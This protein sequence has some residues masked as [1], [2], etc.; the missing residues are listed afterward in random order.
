MLRKVLSHP[1]TLG[2]RRFVRAV[3]ATCAVILAVAFVT[4]LTV[5]LGPVLRA[6]AETEGSR[7]MERPMH[8]GRLSVHLWRGRFVVE[9][10]LIEG[11]TPE[12]RPFLIARRIDVS[13]PWN[14]L[15]NRRIVFDT[16]EMTDWRM[17]VELLKDGRHNFPKFTPRTPRGPS[18]WTTTL[19]YVRAHRGEFTYQDHGTPWSTVARNLDVI[20][21]RPTSEYRGQASFSNGTV[22]IQDYV[23]MRTD[24][25]TTFRIDGGKVV[26]NRIDLLTDGTES[27]LTGVVDLGKWP[28]QTYQV[29]SRIQFPRMREIFFADDTFSLSGEGTFSGTFHLFREQI[30]GRSRTGRELKGTFSSDLAGINDYRFGN[31]KG[32]VLWVP[33]KLEVSD[34]TAAVYGGTARFGYLMAPL[35]VPGVRATATFDAAYQNVDLRTF[36][37]FLELRGLRLAGRATGRNLLA[38]P[39]G[40][41]SERSGEGEVQVAA[42]ADVTLMTRERPPAPAVAA[43]APPPDEPFSN[44]T[45][46]GPVPI[47]GEIA[48]SFGGDG[49]DIAPSRLATKETYVEFEGRTAWGGQSRIPFHVSSADWQESD[50]LLAGIM[51]ALG[52]PTNAIPLGGYGS[53][54]GTMTNTLNQP[55]IEGRF[56]G[57]RIRAFDVVWGTT[58]G[59]VT[60]E[61]AYADA[62]DV[63]IGSGASTIAVNGRFSLGFP[64]RDGGEEINATVRLTGRPVAELRHAFGIDDYDV[65]GLLS[66]EFHVY[67][68]YLRPLGFGQMTIIDGVAYGEPFETASSSLRLEGN[69]VRLDAIQLLKGGGRGTGAAYVDWV[70]GS[71]SFN[72]DARA[73]PVE[74]VRLASSSGLPLSGVVDFTASGSG[75]FDAPRYD[76]RGTIRDFFVADEGIGEVVGEISINDTLMTVRLEAASPRLAVSGSG[77]IELT[78]EMNAD[79]SFRVADTSLDPYVRTY[80]PRLSPFTTAIASGNVRVV[81]QLTNIDELVVEATVDRFDMS[82]FD[83]RLRNA[84]PIRIAL[85]RHTVRVANMRL[86]GEDTAL[87]LSGLINL[88]DNRMAM[89]VGGDAN[90]GILQG[91]VPN[92]RSSGRATL[93]ASIEGGLQEPVVNGTLRVE[94]GRIRHFDLPHALE[95]IS[96]PVRFDARGASFDEVVA[97]LGGGPVRFGGRIDVEGYLP[98]RVDLTMTGENMRLRFPEGMRS[99]VDGTLTLTGAVE[100]P[101]LAGDVT[102]RSAVYTRRFDTGGGLF[103]FGDGEGAAGAA[104]LAPTLPL[105]YDVRINAPSTLRVEN[106]QAQLQA[107]AELQLRGT[108]DRPLLFGRAEIDRGTVSF[109]GRRYTITRGTIDFNNPTRIEPFFD[110]ETE[111]RVRVPGDTYRI[112]VRA[113]GTF[114]RLTPEFVADPPLPEVE[115][116]ALLFSDVAPGQDVELRQYST[117]TPQEQL[118]RDRATRALTGVVSS[119]V[120]RVVEQTFGVDTFQLTPS[121]VDPNAQS[122]RLDPAA[123]VTI[124]KR[125]SDRIYLTYSRSLSSSTRDQIVLLEYDQ[126]DRFSWILSRNEDR[127]YALDVRVRHTF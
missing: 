114:E 119:E 117:V 66:G 70:N 88:H 27:V 111:T 105:R 86:V 56:T 106:T 125:L 107:T 14:T 37:D 94:D 92:I 40:R 103:D 48:Y 84:T 1:I 98:V 87:D 55:R 118:L 67:G 12:S 17:Y 42:P 29:E 31:L 62:R 57:E 22:A 35:G 44:H 99:V 6:R 33:E 122:S 116:L 28:E 65:D 45:P 76:V 74:N 10:L 46:I 20:V 121:L 113:A 58:T 71:Y 13:M 36:S 96:G 24:M 100:A 120:G 9:D 39:L 3:V 53:F 83:Y 4:T 64:R 19:Q 72:L 93:E 108:F 61:N 30:N 43:D 15:V 77:R 50:R 8:I 112:T 91:F 23:P 49:I 69:G 127:T 11:L 124:G 16:I 63:V 54:D 85:D 68:Q 81:G 126:T 109:E 123:R 25:R 115:V 2:T 41:F 47:G 26:L 79:L 21:T 52:N 89:R 97:R 75:S 38:W 59:L 60:I 51:T 18:A 90:L 78:P 32:A 7:Y 110:I 101:I 102:V 80:E 5:D 104:P 34:A 73:I 95:N 82:L